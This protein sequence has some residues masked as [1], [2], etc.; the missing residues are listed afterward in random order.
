MIDRK[1]AD[2][3]AELVVKL[4]PGKQSIEFLD[5]KT[6]YKINCIG[7][8]VKNVIS[9]AKS[10]GIPKKDVDNYLKCAIMAAF[11]LGKISILSENN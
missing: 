2:K 10:A 9:S 7:E 4:H 1:K 8:S 5:E 3:G 11:M 6:A